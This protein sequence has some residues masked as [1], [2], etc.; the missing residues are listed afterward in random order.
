M[1][2]IRLLCRL[3]KGFLWGCIC[4]LYSTRAVSVESSLVAFS[5]WKTTGFQRS[6][7]HSMPLHL[8]IIG[9]LLVV[10]ETANGLF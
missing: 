7:P 3:P 5:A 8:F 10:Y 4:S 1:C 6:A 2:K 9:R